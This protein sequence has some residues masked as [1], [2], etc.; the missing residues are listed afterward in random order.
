MQAFGD[1]NTKSSKDYGREM[2]LLSVEQK[3]HAQLIKSLLSYPLCRH[4]V[5]FT[6]SSSILGVRMPFL[7]YTAMSCWSIVADL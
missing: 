1:S 2:V 7:N 4:T 6:M 5:S 3:L